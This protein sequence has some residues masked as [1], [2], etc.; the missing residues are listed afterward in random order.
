MSKKLLLGFFACFSPAVWMIFGMLFST[1]YSNSL[2]S[3]RELIPT[4]KYVNDSLNGFNEAEVLRL[5]Y[6]EPKRNITY[7]AFLIWAQRAYIARKYYPNDSQNQRITPNPPDPLNLPFCSNSDF[8]MGNFTNWTGCSGCNPDPNGGVCNSGGVCTTPGLVIGSLHTIMGPEPAAGNDPCGNFPVVCPGYT[9]SARLGNALPPGAFVFEPGGVAEELDYKFTV[10]AV[11]NAVFTYN[12]AVVFENPA[13]HTNVQSP[14]FQV[15]VY[16]AAGVA[17]PCSFFNYIAT[18]PALGFAVNNVTGCNPL[19]D[20]GDPVE[21]KPWTPVSVDL[22]LYAGQTLDARFIASDCSLGGHYGYAYIACTCSPLVI[23]QNVPLCGALPVTLSAPVGY[24]TYNWLPGGQHTDSIVTSTPGSYSVTVITSTGCQKQLTYIVTQNPVPVA[25]FTMASALCSLSNVQFTDASTVANPGV[26]TSWHW[27]FGDG[28]IFNGQNPPPHNYLSNPAKPIT[29]VVTTADGC[30]DSISKPF[31]AGAPPSPAFKADTVCLH[32]TTTFTDQTPVGQAASW[33]WNFGEPASGVN[34][35]SAV[36]NPT[37][38]YATAGTFS[39]KLVEASAAGCKDSIT[40]NVV[41][42]PLPVANFTAPNAQCNTVATVTDASTPAG[43]IKTEVWNFGDGTIITTVPPAN[44]PPHTYAALGTDSIKLVVTTFGGCKDSITLPY[45]SGVPPAAAFSDDTVCLNNPSQFTDASTVFPGA[46]TGWKWYFG[47]PSSGVNNTS[48]IQNPTHTYASAGTFTVSLV[49]ISGAG[50]T[51][52]TTRTVVVNPLPVASFASPGVCLNAANSFTDNSTIAGGTIVKWSWNFGDPGS[53]VNNLATTQN[54]THLYSAAGNY[55]VLLTVT[56]NMGC[57]SAFTLPVVVN[58][59][60]N[61]LFSNVNACANSP[62]TFKDS[63]IVNPGTITAWNWNFGDPGSGAGNVAITQN[64]SHA[65]AAAGPYTVTLIVTT[66]AGCMDTIANPVTVY[67]FPVV[68]YTAPAVCQGL[69]TTVTNQSTVVA[70]GTITSAV[71][72]FGDGSPAVPA[73]TDTTHTYALAGI[74]TLSLT[75][76]TANNCASTQ[77]QQDTIWPLPVVKFTSTGVCQG[78]ATAFTDQSTVAAPS[79][80]AGWGWNFGDASPFN[81]TQNP[82]HIYAIAGTDSAQ[83]DAITNNGCIDSIKNP[84]VVFPNPVAIFQG[85]DLTGCGKNFCVELRDTS[86]VAA[87]DKITAWLWNF[88][89]GGT[90]GLPDPKHCYKDTG[91]YS[92]TLTVTTN[93]NCKADTQQLNIIHILLDPTAAFTPS[94]ANPTILNP[95]VN[96]INGSSADV[97]KWFWQFGDGDSLSHLISDPTHTYQPSEYTGGSY[98]V[99]L[100]VINKFGCTDTVSHEVIIAPDWTFFVPNAFTPNG[101]GV[102]DTFNGKGFNLNNYKMI[103]FDRWGNLIYTSHSLT[104]DWD[105]RANGGEK[106]AQQDVYVWKI[107]FD[108]VFGVPHAFI[109]HVTLVR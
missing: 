32:A 9:F 58:P 29:L 48:A 17:I 75:I 15:G 89:D 13:G 46:I 91:T 10:P 85:K 64:P 81:F 20:S 47:E 55:N 30:I 70:P 98:K 31:S 61:A 12:Y 69:K 76:T 5:Y 62:L 74:Y 57:Q 63:S 23:T 36:E 1:L 25:G 16:T 78:L 45:H 21:Y 96:F 73:L 14:Y 88:G 27:E 104:D 2:F 7:A 100:L 26:I 99:T 38:T 71:W 95:V 107:S 102:N 87:P 105:G 19:Y 80:I 66:Q 92:V 101:D 52:S 94:P 6:L 39:V 84:I 11:G 77:T 56:S 3:Q 50:C 22:S 108:D 33:A 83:L 68:I 53:G 51:D 24:A 43:G 8:S 67:P 49:A 42:T 79:V 37:H 90:S 4:V 44:P 86:T 93:N 60:P 54:P 34:N 41:V 35:T 72:N 103:V 97:V 28:N 82:T 106:V 109:G 18:D 59:N 65:Y 40:Q